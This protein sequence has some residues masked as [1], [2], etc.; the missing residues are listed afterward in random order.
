VALTFSLDNRLTDGGKVVD[1]TIRPSFISQ[2]DSWYSF[3]LRGRVDPRVIMW[4][5]GLD[6][7]KN[8][9][10]IG[11]RTRNLPACSIVPQPT[12]LPLAPIAMVLSYL[13]NIN[14]FNINTVSHIFFPL[15][16]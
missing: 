11:I 10:L 13:L 7:L 16:L 8:I 5:E 15:T 9:N 6:K 12:T 3:L 1:L 14:L 2:E 4:L